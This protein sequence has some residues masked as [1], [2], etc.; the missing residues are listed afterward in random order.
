M[1]I[2]LQIKIS[3]RTILDDRHRMSPRIHLHENKPRLFFKKR[4]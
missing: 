4:D 3:Q 2:N 1:K